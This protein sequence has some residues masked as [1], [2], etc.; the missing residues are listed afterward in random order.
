MANTS[1]SNIP[2]A[3]TLPISY[4]SY[5]TDMPYQPTSTTSSKFHRKCVTSAV[6]LLLH[7]SMLIPSSQIGNGSPG[8]PLHQ[9]IG[10][11]DRSH[12]GTVADRGKPSNSACCDREG[13]SCATLMVTFSDEL[14][15]SVRTSASMQNCRRTLVIDT[16][17]TAQGGGGITPHV[18]TGTYASRGVRWRRSHSKH[19]RRTCPPREMLMRR[20]KRS[21]RARGEK[22]SILDG[23][24]SSGSR[25]SG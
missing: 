3:L 20:T 24:A 10:Q 6:A 16:S 23:R 1:L 22:Q 19:R 25:S 17:T 12:S 4:L 21:S 7:A 9:L 18:P 15:W 5:C 2:H 13:T 11:A 14:P 8:P